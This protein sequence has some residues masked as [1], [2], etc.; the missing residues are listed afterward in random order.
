V[1]SA[2]DE[3]DSS[4]GADYIIQTSNFMPIL[5][6]AAEAARA[7][8]EL[9]HV[10]DVRDVETETTM[11]GGESVDVTLSVTQASYEQDFTSDVLEGD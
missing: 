8:S 6:E 4:L 1:A 11:P 9:D 2:T 3:I 5:P 10:T 7:V